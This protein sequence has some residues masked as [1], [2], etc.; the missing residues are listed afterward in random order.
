M[1][2]GG[3]C[4]L[5]VLCSGTNQGTRLSV[6]RVQAQ[7]TTLS[8]LITTHFLCSFHTTYPWTPGQSTT[9]P[10]SPG[11]MMVL[12]LSPALAASAVAGC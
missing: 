9:G 10:S 4:D 12:Q 5:P 7:V 8:K 6:F 3:I 11:G 2:E 1:G